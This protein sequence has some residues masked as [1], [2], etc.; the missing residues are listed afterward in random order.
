MES[1]SIIPFESTKFSR[2]D[3]MQ[4]PSNSKYYRA[5]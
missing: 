2:V 5:R 4:L 3:E 1:F